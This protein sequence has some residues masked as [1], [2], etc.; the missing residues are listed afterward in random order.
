MKHSKSMEKILVGNGAIMLAT[1]FWGVNYAFTQALIPTWMTANDVSAVRLVG[2][3]VLFW[4]ASMFVHC[5][6]LDRDSLVRTLFAGMVGLFGCIFLFILSLKYGSAIDISILMTTPP[7]FVILLEVLFAH[8]H[9]SWLEYAGIV[10]SFAGAALIILSRAA[11]S[12]GGHHL[13]GDLLAIVAALCFAIYLFI[14]AKPSTIYKPITLLRWV[15]LFAAIPALFLVPG[16]FVMPLL[17]APSLQPWFWIG[18]ILF[19]PTFLSYLLTQPAMKDIGA[20]LVSLYQY[21]TPVVAAI[22]AML[23]GL[24]QPRW[25]QGFAMAIIVL[26]MVMT[27]LGKKKEG[28]A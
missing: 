18:F 8:R 12:A 17:G 20:V 26:G 2:G 13:A 10:V 22:S 16:L 3:A 23:M 7:I 4:L 6:K 27:N 1:I 15:F 5:E 19:C 9:P 11:A 25:V 21:L 28:K 24:D 14:L